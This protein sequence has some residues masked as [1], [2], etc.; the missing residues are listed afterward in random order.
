MLVRRVDRERHTDVW[1][2]AIDPSRRLS[3]SE[4]TSFTRSIMPIVLVAMFSKLGPQ[5]ARN[6]FQQLSALRPE[7]VI[8]PLLERSVRSCTYCHVRVLWEKNIP[9]VGKGKNV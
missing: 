8:P 5:E 1:F 2:N 7:I 4:L 9:M 3:D 6:A